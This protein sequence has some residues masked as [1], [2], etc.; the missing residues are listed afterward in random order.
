LFLRAP[1]QIHARHAVD[2]FDGGNDV[3]FGVFGEIGDVPVLG[4]QRERQDGNCEADWLL[5][6]RS[7][8]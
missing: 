2:H 3:V 7:P 6:S 1:D 5:T 8:A 4:R